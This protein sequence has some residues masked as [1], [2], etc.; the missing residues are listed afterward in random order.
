MP[1]MTPEELEAHILLT[2]LAHAPRPGEF[3]FWPPGPQPSTF[4][5]SPYEAAAQS[6]VTQGLIIARVSPDKLAMTAELTVVGR[7]RA[8]ELARQQG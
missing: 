8:E 5:G 4:E 7:D 2:C 1:K 6:L 3:Y